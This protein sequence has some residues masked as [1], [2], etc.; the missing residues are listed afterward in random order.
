MTTAPTPAQTAQ[1]HAMEAIARHAEL[2]ARQPDL[3]AS[4]PP[5]AKQ[6]RAA[7]VHRMREVAEWAWGKARA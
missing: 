5:E 1:R 6:Y 4:A 3:P 2:L 7:Y